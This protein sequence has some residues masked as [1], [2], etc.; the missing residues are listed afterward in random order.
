MIEFINIEENPSEIL[1]L[2]VGDFVIFQNVKFVLRNNMDKTKVFF[3]EVSSAGLPVVAPVG[4]KLW[5]TN[6]Y[7]WRHIRYYKLNGDKE[8]GGTACTSLE[9]FHNWITN[10]EVKVW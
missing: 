8:I 4:E 2:R 9:E 1:H 7:P 10:G 3:D 6:D 5:Q